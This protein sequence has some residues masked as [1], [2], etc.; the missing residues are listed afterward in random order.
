ML[1]TTRKVECIIH[2]TFWADMVS[3]FN[4][5]YLKWEIIILLRGTQFRVCLCQ[6]RVP[7]LPEKSVGW[8]FRMKNQPFKVYIKYISQR[9]YWTQRPDE[10]LALLIYAKIDVL[11]CY[12]ACLK[13]CF[14]STTK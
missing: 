13:Y 14:L 6:Q 3:L 2:D 11:K 1:E 5:T 7:D 4:S 8:A 12:S 9:T 10:G